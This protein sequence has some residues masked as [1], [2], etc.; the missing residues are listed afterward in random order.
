[1]LFKYLK[2]FK[3][4]GSWLLVWWA[5]FIPVGIAVL[6]LQ[7]YRAYLS[8]S[9]A[10]RPP[11]WEISA[12]GLSAIVLHLTAR[13]LRTAWPGV[14]TRVT[15]IATLLWIVWLMLIHLAR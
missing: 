4:P 10:F 13:R 14:A 7:V 3:S 5:L 11:R 15:L 6:V 9:F 2:R 1:M 12:V 8:G